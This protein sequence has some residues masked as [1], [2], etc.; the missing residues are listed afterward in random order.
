V[1]SRV[2][3]DDKSTKAWSGGL[4]I[5]SDNIANLFDKLRVGR[6]LECFQPVRLQAEG[7][8]DARDATN[9]QLPEPYTALSRRPSVAVEAKTGYIGVK[10]RFLMR[11][12]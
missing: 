5:E 1:R 6:E 8:P 11:M 3:A 2:F 10:K 7:P 9:R 12:F 4:E